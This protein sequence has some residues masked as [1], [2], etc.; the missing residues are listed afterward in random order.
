MLNIVYIHIYPSIYPSIQPAIHPS[1]HLPI[2]KYTVH[3]THPHT[4]THTYI[5]I[6]I[7][8]YTCI[9][10]QNAHIHAYTG[11]IYNVHTRI[12]VQ[13]FDFAGVP[14]RRRAGARSR[15][16]CRSP[17]WR[18]EMLGSQSFTRKNLGLTT[19][20]MGTS[21]K[22][23]E[24]LGISLAKFDPNWWLNHRKGWHLLVKFTNKKRDW[25]V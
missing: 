1:I 4:R 11:D 2:Y 19:W 9:D 23:M 20:N 24:N 17:C 6:Y 21:R 3:T 13:H 16:R 10:Q 22:I 8:T 14:S 12:H 25:G 15:C 18:A 5:Y 7:H